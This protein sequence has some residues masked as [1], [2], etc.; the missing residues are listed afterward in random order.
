LRPMAARRARIWPLPVFEMV[1][2]V[3]AYEHMKLR[4]LNGTHSSLAYLGY[5]AGHETI[6]DAVADPSFARFVK[7]LWSEE[8]IPSFKAPEGVDT[9]GLCRCAA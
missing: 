2:D 7:R 8:I 3:T 6:S 4:M 1:R 9:A 5:L